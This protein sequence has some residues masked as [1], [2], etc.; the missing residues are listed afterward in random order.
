MGF[1]LLPRLL[2]LEKSY[3]YFQYFYLKK[4]HTSQKVVFSPLLDPYIAPTSQLYNN[5]YTYV[6]PRTTKVFL[7]FKYNYTFNTL[8]NHSEFI[9]TKRLF[10]DH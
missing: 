1:R 9:F 5:L 8:F 2:G 3:P 4:G 6:N 7:V 10:E